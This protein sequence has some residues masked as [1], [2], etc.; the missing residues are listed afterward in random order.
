MVPAKNNRRKPDVVAPGTWILSTRSSA[1]VADVGPD[2]LPETGDEDGS[3]THVEA[4]GSA[5][6][7]GPI[8]GTGNASAPLCLHLPQLALRKITCI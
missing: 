7:G 6:A 1:A 8:F 2:G 5:L 3:L 4:V